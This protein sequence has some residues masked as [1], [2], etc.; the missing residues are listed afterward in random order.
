M[1][2]L[3][4][5]RGGVQL[6]QCKKH[7]QAKSVAIASHSSMPIHQDKMHEGEAKQKSPK[8]DNFLKVAWVVGRV[9]KVQISDIVDRR[10]LQGRL[11][12]VM[13]GVCT[14]P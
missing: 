14:S 6:T 9:P 4:V 10:E 11:P 2:E 5:S 8:T 7:K 1:K 12:T 13:C 3:K